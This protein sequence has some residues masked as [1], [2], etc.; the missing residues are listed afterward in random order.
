MVTEAGV[1][2]DWDALARLVREHFK[3]GW[4]Y[5]GVKKSSYHLI[6][7][8]GRE[9]ARKH[10][11]GHL[12]PYQVEE[13]RRQLRQFIREGRGRF[14]WQPQTDLEWMILGQH[15]RLPTRL[16]DRSESLLVAAYFEIEDVLSEAAIY[17]VKPP[18]EITN[19]DAN[20]FGLELGDTPRLVR[21]PHLNPRITAQRGVLTLHPKPDEAWDVPE[22]HR[23]T[24]PSTA[25][26][27]LKG[28]LA[29]CGIHAASLFPDGA[30]RHTEY[31]G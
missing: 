19:L 10:P 30:G 9:N 22:I 1:I 31:I 6:P 11:H 26:F 25:T 3:Q 29:L 27:T 7:S 16:L 21:P 2:Q 23:W 4:I 20:P 28:V 18:P 15:H 5:R 14:D 12:L 13:E 24:I 8:I 17:G